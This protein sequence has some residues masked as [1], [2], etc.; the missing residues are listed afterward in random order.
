MC[1]AAH[2]PQRHSFLS[3]GVALAARQRENQ[4][5]LYREYYARIVIKKCSL[6]IPSEMPNRAP[7][8][9]DIKK[10]FLST[11]S[12]KLKRWGDPARSGSLADWLGLSS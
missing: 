4:L 11:P 6:W 9:I 2:S 7:G 12:S 5:P 3:F 10:A 8:T 1:A